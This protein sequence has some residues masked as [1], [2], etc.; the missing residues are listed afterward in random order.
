M[1]VLVGLG[2]PGVR[3]ATTRH[4]VGFMVVERLAARWAIRLD[5]QEQRRRVGVGTVAGRAALLVQPGL[6]MNRCGEALAELRLEW[7]DVR[8]VAIFDDLDLA[9]GQL[10]LRR[11]GGA[12]GH[13]GV[14]SILERFGPGF[15][16]IRIGIGRP[17]RG[18]DAAEYVLR[19]MS[20]AEI[21]GLAET[22][23]R[24]CD[25][26]ECLLSEG[27][28][29]AMNRFNGRV[30]GQERRPAQNGEDE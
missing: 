26:V 23:E 10:R 21:L 4:N 19:E 28:E 12:G 2:N 13:R 1:H 20:P 27:I 5:W 22:I 30:P 15:D 9:E 25:A 8:I 16:R 17:P 24:G 29:A 7:N 3:Y 6:F 18:V 11:N 14:A